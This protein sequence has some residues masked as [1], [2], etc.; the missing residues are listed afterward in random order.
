MK[1]FKF[2]QNWGC[3]LT[4]KEFANTYAAL[5]VLSAITKEFPYKITSGIKLSNEKTD[6]NPDEKILF[7]AFVEYLIAFQNGF[8]IILLT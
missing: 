7:K 6:L 5:G 4:R 3:E 1:N 8:S 2:W